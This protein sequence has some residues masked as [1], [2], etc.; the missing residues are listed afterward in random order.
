VGAALSRDRQ[1]VAQVVPVEHGRVQHFCRTVEQSCGCPVARAE[2]YHL[3]QL[4][5]PEPPPQEETII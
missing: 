1:K 2:C 4:P 5:M 3:K